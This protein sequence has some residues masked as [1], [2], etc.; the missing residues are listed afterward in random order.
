MEVFGGLSRIF[1]YVFGNWKHKK[2]QR[3]PSQDACALLQ[4]PVE[5]IFHIADHLPRHGLYILAQTCFP[6]QYIVTNRYNLSHADLLH[7]H[8]EALDYLACRSRDRLD[9]WVCGKHI[10]L[11]AVNYSDLPKRKMGIVEGTGP[12]DTLL[13]A[14]HAHVQLAI[15]YTRLKDRLD[16]AGHN[17]LGRLLAFSHGHILDSSPLPS[18]E[19]GEKAFELWP[20]VVDGRFLLWYKFTVFYSLST[21]HATG[22][23]NLQAYSRVDPLNWDFC[24]HQRRN[25]YAWLAANPDM[26]ALVNTRVAANEP[27][28]CA[29]CHCCATDVAVL[30]RLASCT[31]QIWVDYGPEAS[32]ENPCWLSR[33]TDSHIVYRSE[34]G[35]VRRLYGSAGETR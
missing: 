20:R 1:S 26:S 34:P 12:R 8:T 32:P 27:E 24:R 4:L 10:R 25:R 29:S 13:N 21:I 9:R 18:V 35:R 16:D 17:Y 28:I 19:T 2:I 31:V 15:K 33:L 3:R 30:R 6:M 14:S 5:V 22:R 23:G 7:N 11:R